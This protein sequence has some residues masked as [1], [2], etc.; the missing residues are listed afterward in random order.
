MHLRIISSMD[1]AKEYQAH[2]QA[3]RDQVAQ[4]Q[5]AAAKGDDVSDELGKLVAS[6]EKAEAARH[7]AAKKEQEQLR[8]ER[9]ALPVSYTHLTLPTKA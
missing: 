2:L 8:R 1:K 5:G 6:L 4:A 7:E 3:L 9:W